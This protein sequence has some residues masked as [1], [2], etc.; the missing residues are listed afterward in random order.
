MDVS[1]LNNDWDQDRVPAR[2]LQAAK[3][4]CLT[5]RMSLLT[6]RGQGEAKKYAIYVEEIFRKTKLKDFHSKI[7]K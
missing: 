3:N 6:I 4:I 1:I 7:N 5:N 2:T